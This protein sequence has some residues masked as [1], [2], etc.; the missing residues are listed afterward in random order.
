MLLLLFLF[1]RLLL[2]NYYLS[3]SQSRNRHAK[4]RCAHVIHSNLVTEFD[5]IRIAAVLAANANLQLAAGVAASFNAP[6]HQ[7]AHTLRI[8]GLERIRSK[9]ARF[10]F[11]HIVR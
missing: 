10:L 2:F 3:C 4:W 1:G 9:N 8:E 7:H 5:A 6:S 11:V